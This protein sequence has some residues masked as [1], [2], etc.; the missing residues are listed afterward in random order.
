MPCYIH[1]RSKGVTHLIRPE[2]TEIKLT[3]VEAAVSDEDTSLIN[4]SKLSKKKGTIKAT[5][6]FKGGV[7]YG[8]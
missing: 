2:N 5:L 1:Y 7:N 3:N 4:I 8:K 6:T